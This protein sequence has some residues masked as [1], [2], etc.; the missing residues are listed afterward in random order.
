MDY[1]QSFREAM[2]GKIWPI[3]TR[4]VQFK[5]YSEDDTNVTHTAGQSFVLFTE[6]LQMQRII[7]VLMQ[8]V[9]S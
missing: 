9:L 5:D 6:V 1:I 4:E 3:T 7:N 8:R 2:A